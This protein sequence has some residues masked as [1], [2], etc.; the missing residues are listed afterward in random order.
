MEKKFDFLKIS[1]STSIEINS[2][3]ENINEITLN[4]YI[5]HHEFRKETKEFLIEKAQQYDS[6]MNFTKLIQSKPLENK[7]FPKDKNRRIYESSINNNIFLKNKKRFL[8][9]KDKLV[10]R[11]TST[12]KINAHGSY[13]ALNNLQ[14]LIKNDKY[15]NKKLNKRVSSNAID[16]NLL[17]LNEDK[18]DSININD[19]NFYKKKFLKSIDNN[20]NSIKKRKKLNELDI[21]TS[22]IQKTSLNLNQPEAFYAGLFNNI[23]NKDYLQLK[24]PKIIFN[25]KR[26]FNNNIGENLIKKVGKEI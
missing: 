15:N 24:E 10:I 5:S 22:N 16:N 3:Y 17:K 4:K 18:D 7:F 13:E 12:N 21:I 20:N 11:K 14:G 8:E 6:K 23:I 19:L 9:N 25:S 26:S 2:S 1:N